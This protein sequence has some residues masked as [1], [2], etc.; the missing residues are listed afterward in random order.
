[1]KVFLL[2]ILFITISCNT[3]LLDSIISRLSHRIPNPKIQSQIFVTN[4]H[5]T[6]I[7]ITMNNSLNKNALSTLLNVD[8]SQKAI[9]FFESHINDPLSVNIDSYF[10]YMQGRTKMSLTK[11]AYGMEII[12]DQAH[13]V[14]FEVEI[15]GTIYKNDRKMLVPCDGPSRPG[16]L[17]HRHCRQS[18]PNKGEGEYAAYE[19]QLIRRQLEEKCNEELIQRINDLKSVMVKN[20]LASLE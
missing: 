5:N 18:R 15:E 4:I 11:S 13:I 9:K 1:M 3:K 20:F 8:V 12:D 14:Y 19:L 17:I 6:K 2:C 7:P 16:Q 10:N